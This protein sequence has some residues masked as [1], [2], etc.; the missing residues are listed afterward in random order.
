MAIPIC[1][2]HALKR[3][4]Q[5][6]HKWLTLEIQLESAA[7]ATG[8]IKRWAWPGTESNRR[9]EDFQS[10]DGTGTMCHYWSAS[11]SIQAFE[12]VKTRVNLPIRTDSS[13]WFW[14]SS[15][16]VNAY[17]GVHPE[18]FRRDALKRIP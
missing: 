16:K 1:T 6:S 18:E 7:F 13:K 10:C 3:K 2:V 17:R 5:L 15:D 4:Q 11:E 12:P 8:R 14:Q 9:D